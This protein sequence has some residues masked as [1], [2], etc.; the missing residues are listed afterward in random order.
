MTPPAH[1]LRLS[2]QVIA[3]LPMVPLYARVD[4]I[5]STQGAFLVLEL[6]EPGLHFTFAPEQAVQFAK[7]IHAQLV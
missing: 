5:L 4:G 1:L 2:E 7:V 3:N 6:N